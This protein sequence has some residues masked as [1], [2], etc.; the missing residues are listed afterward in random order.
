MS[1]IKKKNGIWYF[2]DYFTYLDRCKNQ[3]PENIR[4][5][6]LN[7]E[8]YL[9]NGKD[10]LYDSVLK[11]LRYNIG[12]YQKK[13]LLY[14]SFWDSYQKRSI[15]FNFQ[16]VS[17]MKLNCDIGLLRENYLL[18]HQFKIKSNNTFQYE[19]IFIDK[20]KIIIDFQRLSIEE[21]E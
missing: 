18:T 21:N 10:T 9:I 19:F 2:D 13:D 3:I 11:K 15:I 1:I 5:F 8:R 17:C 7:P 4:G 14:I 20:S 12:L 16:L 6:V